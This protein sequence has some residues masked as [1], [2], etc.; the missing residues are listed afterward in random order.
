M[1]TKTSVSKQDDLENLVIH[2][3]YMAKQFPDNDT[4]ITSISYTEQFCCG[5][6]FILT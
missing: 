6:G 1:S 2:S 4:L 3:F 5:F